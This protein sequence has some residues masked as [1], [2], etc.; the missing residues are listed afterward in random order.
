[1]QEPVTD[2]A[3]GCPPVPALV[4]RF[5]VVFLGALVILA[6]VLGRRLNFPAGLLVPQDPPTAA[7]L[8]ALFLPCV[9]LLGAVIVFLVRQLRTLHRAH[10]RL[11][12]IHAVA[13][14]LAASL[15]PQ[16]VLQ[17][18][19][20]AVH[21]LLGCR[22]VALMMVRGD[23]LVPVAWAGYASRPA[24]LR[25]SEGWEAPEAVPT[26]VGSWKATFPI[27]VEG[28]LVG[29]LQVETS[30]T[31]RLERD[32]L[33]AVESVVLHL[34]SALQNAFR[35]RQARELALRDG[36]TGLLNHTGFQERL[37]EEVIRARSTQR[38][39]TLILA[40][41]DDFKAVNDTYG[42]L[43]GDRLLQAFSALLRRSIRTTD[44]AAR[45]GG[46]EF[47]VLLLGLRA[48][49]ALKIAERIRTA[50]RAEPL[51]RIDAIPVSVT[52]SLGVA[53]F[54]DHATDPVE[55]LRAAD[56]ALYRAK[57]N[58]KDRTELATPLEV[59]DRA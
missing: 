45:Y 48:E 42:H 4:D 58:G 14:I 55:L 53:G 56:E 5:R 41:L 6:T 29:M 59:G 1:M 25:V 17:R 36:L 3:R 22:R 43:E 34:G 15:E 21:R 39:F 47:A 44:V 30:R 20:D 54:P 7:L 51:V 24:D 12:A 50:A 32:D 9:A 10:D 16:E 11:H 31:R 46:E 37:H 18:S 57:R 40:D 13:R 8:N 28:Q 19:V 26:A 33:E 23:R 38:P 2:E 35:Y 49:E 27:R 52:V